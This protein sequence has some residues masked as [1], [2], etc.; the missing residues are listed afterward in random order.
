MGKKEPIYWVLVSKSEDLLYLNYNSTVENIGILIAENCGHLIEEFSRFSHVAILNEK[1]SSAIN[2]NTSVNVQR[3]C[4]HTDD[5]TA[6]YMADYLV[7]KIETEEFDVNK[8]ILQLIPYFLHKAKNPEQK[9]AI[10]CKNPNLIKNMNFIDFLNKLQLDSLI[11]PAS[12]GISEIIHQDVFNPC[13]DVENASEFLTDFRSSLTDLDNKIMELLAQ[14]MKIV[15]QIGIHKQEND[16]R[17]FDP[18]RFAHTLRLMKDKAEAFNMEKVPVQRI[19]TEIQLQ[20]L[21]EMFVQ[22]YGDKN[23]TQI[24]SNNII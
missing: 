17:Y 2:I 12:N 15:K 4:L 21:T 16:L 20:S 1:N 23:S 9:A 19:F 11:I 18:L 5:L 7:F 6:E 8:L 13:L 10:I 14:R 3:F 22:L 24:M